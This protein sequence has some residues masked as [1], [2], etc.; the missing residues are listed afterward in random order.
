MKQ[1]LFLII[2]II[3]CIGCK[4]KDLDEIANLFKISQIVETAYYFVVDTSI[5]E[6]RDAH[7]EDGFCETIR[8]A[9]VT[10]KIV[11]GIFQA[12]SFKLITQYSTE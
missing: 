7:S 1:N 5:D 3:I 11:D 8:N 6:H 2:S 9:E 12:E 4:V 10:G